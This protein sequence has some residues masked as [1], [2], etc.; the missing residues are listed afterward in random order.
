MSP[1]RSHKQMI[2]LYI[3]NWYIINNA[4]KSECK[5]EQDDSSCEPIILQGDQT[6][7]HHGQI[8]FTHEQFKFSL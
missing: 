1:P 6:H 5:I 2:T 4:N 7:P 8:I 3:K